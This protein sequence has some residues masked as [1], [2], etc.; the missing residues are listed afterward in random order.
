M[1]PG[2]VALQRE[3]E[4]LLLETQVGCIGKTGGA[5]EVALGLRISCDGCHIRGLSVA[6]IETVA[7]VPEF[8]LVQG[9]AEFH[10]AVHIPV[11]VDVLRPGGANARHRVVGVGGG[12]GVVR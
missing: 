12:D 9:A 6:D 5:D 4:F 11:A 2:H 3:A 10:I 1:L 7:E 8:L